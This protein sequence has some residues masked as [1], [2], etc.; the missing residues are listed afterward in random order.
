MN[1]AKDDS[2]WLKFEFPLLKSGPDP[3]W[4]MNDGT[5]DPDDHPEGNLNTGTDSD[6]CNASYKFFLDT[7]EIRGTKWP[8]KMDA[9]GNTLLD[10][11]NKCAG[12][13]AV[14]KWHF[15][16]A[17]DNDNTNAWLAS[18]QIVIG[19]KSC[20]G[21]AVVTAGGPTKGSCTGAG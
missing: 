10:E 3:I 11:I 17:P 21:N 7:F 18:G 14:T 16:L 5:L 19:Q 20:V 9:D 2:Y 8:K 15:E 6:T 1:I 13:K 12:P 4:A